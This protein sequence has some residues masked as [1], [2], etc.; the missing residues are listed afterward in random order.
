MA[1]FR[2][3]VDH[4]LNDPT[5][6][7]TM[8]ISMSGLPGT[9]KTTIASE[10]ARGLTAV[11]LRVDSIELSL[12]CDGWPVEGEGYGIAQ[13]VAEDNL[14]LGRV[15]VADSVN[16]WPATRA[17][18]R[19]VAERTGVPILDVELVCSDPREH[20]RRVEAGVVGI[21]GPSMWTWQ[22]VVD[23]DYRAWD[24][25]RIVIDTALLTIDQCVEEILVKI[26][27]ER[28]QSV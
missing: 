28:P 12:S 21:V 5:R 7:A 13:A 18:W 11:Y 20:R 24:C 27:S 10:L 26:P 17:G 4:T 14:R 25:Q 3:L 16:P 22:R 1:R 23:F 15:V 8:L 19:V 9:G 6:I 2:G